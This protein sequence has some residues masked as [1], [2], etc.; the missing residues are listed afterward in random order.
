MLIAVF[1]MYNPLRTDHLLRFRPTQPGRTLPISAQS[2]L[3]CWWNLDTTLNRR[4]SRFPKK[5]MASSPLRRLP[6]K[7]PRRSFL[8]CSILA[9][10]TGLFDPLPAIAAANIKS[11]LIHFPLSSRCQR[12]IGTKRSQQSKT[13]GCRGLLSRDHCS[14]DGTVRRWR[15][16]GVGYGNV[17][18]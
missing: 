11:A 1:G 14:G 8:R 4:S 5:G 7:L 13:G 3:R 17:S 16:Q 2:T 18:S 12:R 10:M 6:A 15:K 9:G